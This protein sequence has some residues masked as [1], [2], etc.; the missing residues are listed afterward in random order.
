MKHR[1]CIASGLSKSS[2]CG[3]AASYLVNRMTA[4]LVEI[5]GSFDKDEYELCEGCRRIMVKTDSVV[6]RIMNET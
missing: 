2:L 3:H 6:R 4:R 5:R 1:V